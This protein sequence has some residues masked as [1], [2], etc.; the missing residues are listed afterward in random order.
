MKEQNPMP[1]RKYTL[2][3]IV[4]LSLI[5][6]SLGINLI[7][8]FASYNS[9][10]IK[11]SSFII[12][13]LG[14][15]LFGVSLLGYFMNLK[16]N[17]LLKWS[18]LFIGI[19]YII[20]FFS[21]N[22]FFTIFYDEFGLVEYFSSSSIFV[23]YS[24]LVSIFTI[25]FGYAFSKLGKINKLIGFFSVLFIA[26]S[27]YVSSINIIT[28]QITSVLR[29][30]E[31]EIKPIVLEDMLFKYKFLD[32]LSY[33]SMLGVFIILFINQKGLYTKTFKV[34]V[35]TIVNPYIEEQDE[36]DAE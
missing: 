31:L 22:T 8:D 7:V 13:V 34:R 4:G 32:I 17:R 36:S 27:I 3:G 15:V 12:Q 25:I 30:V 21:I 18:S 16:E 6:L 1:I 2:I 29:E 14:N 23:I 24:L 26:S 20:N 11:Y 19:F 28:N 5:I 33:I 9:N 10:F 35:N